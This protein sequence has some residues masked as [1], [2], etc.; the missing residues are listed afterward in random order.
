MNVTRN[1]NPHIL[2]LYYHDL[3]QL[4]K[5]RLLNQSVREVFYVQQ[6]QQYVHYNPETDCYEH[7]GY[8]P[9]VQCK[10]IFDSNPNLRHHVN[11]KVLL[12]LDNNKLVGIFGTKNYVNG[13]SAKT[14]GIDVLYKSEQQILP[15]T[16]VINLSTNV[17]W[18]NKLNQKI[19]QVAVY[20]QDWINEKGCQQG[21]PLALKLCFANKE[22][23]WIAMV[24][25]YVSDSMSIYAEGFITLYFSE[26]AQKAMV[27]GTLTDMATHIDTIH[28]R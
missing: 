10:D 23:V 4:V 6:Q 8:Y 16:K 26:E 12:R 21:Y 9:D 5:S 20:W 11:H 17:M 22:A 3:R 28:C 14:V 18:R 27:D 2:P 19:T 7:T 25:E 1:T 15:D 24:E 13:W